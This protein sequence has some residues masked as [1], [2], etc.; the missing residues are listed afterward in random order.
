MAAQATIHSPLTIGP[1]RLR[2]RLVALPVFTGYAYPDGSVSPL[3]LSHYTQL[4]ASGVAMVVVA[5]TAVSAD[6]GTSRYNLRIDEERFVPG[7]E[8]L[9]RAIH[10][11]RALAC[12]QLNHA[13]RFAKTDQPLLASPVDT[14]NLVHNISALKD[15]INS[16]PFEK[17]FG[18]TR[19]FLKMITAWHRAATDQELDMVITRFGQAARRAQQAGFDMIELHGA[20]GYLLCEFLSPA[21]NKRTSGFGGSFENRM[22]LPLGVVREIQRTLPAAMPVG[23]RLLLNEWVPGGIEIEESIA[24]AQALETV[25]VSYISAAS[26]TFNS[27]F[28]PQVVKR[29]ATRAYLR[30]AMVKLHRQIT[31]PTIISGRVITPSL[32]N[33]LLAQQTADLIGLGRPLRV[34]LDWVRKSLNRRPKIKLCVNCNFCLKNVILEQGFIC[35]RWTAIERLATE[36]EHLLLTRNYNSLWVICDRN[37]LERFKAG[38]PALLP[39]APWMQPQQG[40]TVLFLRDET[41]EG[42]S[43][44]EKADFITWIQQQAV[45]RGHRM[46]TPAVK[47][48]MVQGAWDQ[49]VRDE[50]ERGN[51]GMVLIARDRDQ[52][53]RR[54]LL[55][56]LHHKVVG[57]VSPNAR[58]H[59][60]AVLVDFSA[61]SLLMLNFLRQAYGNR[62]E[63]TMQFI[64]A[65]DGDRNEPIQR[66]WAELKKAVDLHI[67]APL[68]LI[69]SQGNPTAAI[70][71][72]IA[73]GP[74][75]TIVMGKR[76][77]S[78]IKRLL[79]GSVSKA[80]LRNAEDHSLFL[81]D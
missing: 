77:L 58:V 74:Y 69:P 12:L 28:K 6:G 44:K 55:Y 38:L 47:D 2:N 50:T 45:E 16:F 19:L 36:L 62:P 65:C 63:V 41:T 59:H 17:R 31:I 32:A 24:L 52:L 79:L 76:G 46:K 81:V 71:D 9:A 78:G 39:T 72:A 22:T 4:A 75:G 11:Q 15:F 35:R 53:W 80:V 21:T 26:G 27:I 70:I 66:R 57:L 14:S 1:Y 20:N 29:M 64:H 34:D 30:Q 60:V 25:G 61:P 40:A 56:T 73:A 23:F 54:R 48:L 10:G 5:N 13:G 8:T 51:F 42:C 33:E 3:L 67:D 37:D 7:L 68:K 43:S 49:A 18:L